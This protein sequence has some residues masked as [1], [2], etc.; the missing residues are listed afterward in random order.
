MQAGLRMNAQ[1]SRQVPEELHG[2]AIDWAS[3]HVFASIV[4]RCEDAIISATIDGLV[5]TWNNSAERIFGY[6]ASEMVGQPLARLLRGDDEQHLN[7]HLARLRR[8]EHIGCYETVRHSKSG[9]QI[10]VCVTCSP[11]CDISNQVIGLSEIVREVPSS[12]QVGRVERINERL[13]A[14]GRLASRIAHEI[15]NPL[16]A[17]TNL[18]FLIQRD[19]L[20]AES[21]QYLSLAQGE[22]ARIATI[23]AHSLGI[24]RYSSQPGLCAV[25]GIVDEAIIQCRDKIETA[26]IMVR[27]DYHPVSMISFHRDELHHVML[28]VVKNALDAMPSGG[29]LHLRIRGRR[30]WVSGRNGVLITVGDTG[31]G[32]TPETRARLFEPFFST[33]DATRTGLG[34]WSCAH[35]IAKYGGR[36]LVKSNESGTVVAMFLPS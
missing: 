13:R 15:N 20:T 21:A 17:I 11:V 3:I 10:P 14:M 35:I 30:D 24:Y 2:S 1:A 26:G 33:K 8:G 27:R 6:T 32:M 36:I 22:I 7:E 28:N 16:T 18:L 9:E 34:L 23:S 12:E 31:K 29:A 25:M 5:L 19:C 4:N